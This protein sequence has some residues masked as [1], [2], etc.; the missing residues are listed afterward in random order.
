MAG[1]KI[2]DVRK[3][4][5]GLKLIDYLDGG[6]TLFFENEEGRLYTIDFTGADSAIV[7]KGS[8]E[9]EEMESKMML[10][11][12]LLQKLEISEEELWDL[13]E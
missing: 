6:K 3:E 2:D 8:T 7:H 11:S 1:M 10:F 5:L 12:L 9:K 4:I 13:Y